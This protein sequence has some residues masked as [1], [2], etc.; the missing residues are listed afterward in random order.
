MV[1]TSHMLHHELGI[2][3]VIADYFANQRPVPQ[4]NLFWKNKLIYL[5]AGFGTL[6]IPIVFDL[7]NKLGIDHEQLLN[8]EHVLLMEQGFDLLRR[9]EDKMIDQKAFLQGCKDLLSGKVKQTRLAEDLFSVFS[10][11]KPSCFP[12][13][14]TSAALSRSDMFLF[15]LVDLPLSDT[16]VPKFIP[17]W[18]AVARPILIFDDFVDLASDRLSGESENVI[19]EF[20]NDR[21]A[22]QKAFAL[23]LADITLLAGIN[24]KLA[25]FM[26]KKLE[27]CLQLKYIQSQLKA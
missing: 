13:D 19:I 22:I 9:F 17:Y 10:G 23:G 16:W 14:Q 7:Q 11:A 12:L 26:R 18:Y 21:H 24:A 2:D 6:T 1:I 4:Q 25:D 20:G 3:S 5:Y 8:N 15:T 27:K